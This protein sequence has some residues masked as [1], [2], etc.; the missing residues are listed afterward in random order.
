MTTVGY[1]DLGVQTKVGKMFA[2]AWV[3]FG[4]VAFGLL[5][6]ELTTHIME[7]KSPQIEQM[8]GKIV[9]TPHHT[10]ILASVCLYFLFLF[11]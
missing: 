4:I 1:G 8:K 5:T 11:L 9:T 10:N 2:V 7:L 6:G 3:T